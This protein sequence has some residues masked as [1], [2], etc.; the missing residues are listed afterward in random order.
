[1]IALL[2]L[3][4]IFFCLGSFLNCMAYRLVHLQHPRTSRSCCPVCKQIIAWYD[5][6]PVISWIFLRARCRR[7]AAPIS[8]LYP[9]IELLTVII[10]LG[11]IYKIPM[12]YLFGY[13]IFFA[14]LII[15]IRTDLETMLISRFVTLCLIPIGFMLSLLGLLPIHF[16]QALLGTIFGYFI[17]W[18]IAKMFYLLTGKHG[19]GEGD[20]DLLAFIGSFTGVVGVWLSLLLGSVV[21][22]IV[23]ILLIAWSG[24]KQ[25]TQPIPF[26][27]FLAG[28]AILYVLFQTQITSFLLY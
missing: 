10:F 20:Y 28:G 26:G 12:E 7:C 24:K 4:P 18:G 16:S 22:S 3:I 6:I 9:L 15:S 8:F 19:M 1:M 23:G 13:G 17:L 21:G 14:A 11:L 25:M 27:P 5:L 2:L